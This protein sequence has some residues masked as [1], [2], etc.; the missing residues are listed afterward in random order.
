MTELINEQSVI[1]KVDHNKEESDEESHE[2]SHEE[3]DDESDDE[4]NYESDDESDQYDSDDD[5]PVD[6]MITG[7]PKKQLL[8]IITYI[9]SK[10][11]QCT[12]FCE[13]SGIDGAE[14]NQAYFEKNILYIIKHNSSL[15]KCMKEFVDHAI[16]NLEY[17]ID[18]DIDIYH[19]QIMLEKAQN[20]VYY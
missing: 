4:S 12:Q 8:E 19:N 5:L 1:E 16:F 20:M 10:N 13:D 17:N 2:E 14:D 3:S 7:I 15:P 9:Y 11:L 6:I 18:D